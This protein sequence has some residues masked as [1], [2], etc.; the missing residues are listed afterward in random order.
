M[1]VK[2][3]GP[4]FILCKEG[5]KDVEDSPI[6]I[7][8]DV[9]IEIGVIPAI[10]LEGGAIKLGDETGLTVNDTEGDTNGDSMEF[11][12][13]KLKRLVDGAGDNIDSS[14]GARDSIGMA[15]FFKSTA[16]HITPRKQ[17]RDANS[18]LIANVSGSS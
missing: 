2:S 13:E 5:E 12:G 9:L 11:S 18:I 10:G 6:G 7:I 14:E 15:S 17:D 4:L 1:L 8:G 16:H 3:L